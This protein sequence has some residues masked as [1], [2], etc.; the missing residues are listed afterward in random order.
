MKHGRTYYFQVE[1]K[2][3]FMKAR[4]VC[5]LFFASWFLNEFQLKEFRQKNDVSRRVC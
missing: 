1:T 2:G 5:S 4:T 3:A